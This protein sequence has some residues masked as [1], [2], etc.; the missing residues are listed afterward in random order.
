LI[1]QWEILVAKEQSK[2]DNSQTA[3]S[4]VPVVGGKPVTQAEFKVKFY[5]NFKHVVSP[6][7]FSLHASCFRML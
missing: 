7:D 5:L 1:R 2:Q 3:K 6:F 4:K